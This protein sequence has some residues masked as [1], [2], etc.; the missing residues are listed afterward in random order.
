MV[1]LDMFG[2]LG[3]CAAFPKPLMRGEVRKCDY[4]YPGSRIFAREIIRYADKIGRRDVAFD[5]R[6]A[7][8]RSIVGRGLR[9]VYWRIRKSL[10]SIKGWN[11][12]NDRSA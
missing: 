12:R 9:R 10:L 5:F 4:T 7:V 2:V 8:M 1:T 3:K 11:S 6:Y